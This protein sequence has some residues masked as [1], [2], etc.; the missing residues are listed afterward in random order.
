VKP[1]NLVLKLAVVGSSLLLGGCFVSYR[2]GAFNWLTK[3]GAGS[4]DTENPATPEQSP[5]DGTSQADPTLMSG[6]KSLMPARTISGLT[7]ADRP[8]DTAKQVPPARAPTL[9]P[10]P[11]SDAVFVPPPL[12]SSERS[13]PAP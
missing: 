6:S 9:M 4:A 2:T 12:P 5:S 7:P 1:A 11:K 8:P 10:G 13:K 3:P